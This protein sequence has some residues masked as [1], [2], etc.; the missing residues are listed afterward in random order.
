MLYRCFISLLLAAFTA[1]AA[2][3][4]DENEEAIRAAVHRNGGAA[5]EL[6]EEAV[7]I[8][9]GTLNAKGVRAVGQLFRNAFEDVGF[10]TRWIDGEAFG[11][12]GHLVARYGSRGPRVLLIGH[13]DTVFARDSEFQ[14]FERIDE[15]YARGPGISDM[16]GGN[17][18]ILE[19]V[20]ALAAA[21]VLDELQLCVVLT[22]DE[23]SRGAPLALANREL[24]AAGDW[25]DIALGFED[26]DSDP[27]TA[28]TARRSSSRWTLTVTGK[29]A[30]SSQIFRDD[31][32]YGAA[33]EIARILDEWRSALSAVPNL[34]FNPGM[35]MAGTDLER[36]ADDTRGTV[37]GKG[38]VIARSAIATGGM[39]AISPEQ[40]AIAET[41]MRRILAENLPHTSATLEFDHGYPPMAPTE[42]NERL[43]TVYS[44]LSQELGHG[45]VEAVD[46]RRAGAA[47]I[48]FVAA[49]VGAAL[50]GLGLM[51]SGGHTVNEV[52]DLFTLS[53]QTERAA[54]LLYRIA[55]GRAGPDIAP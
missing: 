2:L 20:K 49:R 6:L 10:S 33:L 42:G 25:A 41:A 22:G 27:R 28:V 14:R 34:T 53:S 31:V 9:S 44:E 50:D 29:A 39:R 1:P 21:G 30:H 16:K 51:G 32:G 40:I 38:N 54:L 13:L 3:A 26:G 5:L 18:V 17:V 43:L 52:A 12:G 46:P 48:S 55:R 7:N 15:R 37:F 45:P 19:A 35:V 47:D 24:L 8:N 23:E 4:L 11:R 36:G